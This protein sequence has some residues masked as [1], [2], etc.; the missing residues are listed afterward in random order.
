MSAH[1]ELPPE[2]LVVA[3]GRPEVAS[4]G[5]QPQAHEAA[6][7]L[8][9]QAGAEP[10]VRQAVFGLVGLRVGDLDEVDELG[11]RVRGE[12]LGKVAG[13][14]DREV[15]AADQDEAVEVLRGGQG[16]A[17]QAEGGVEL[18]VI[19]PLDLD[20]V[21]ALAEADTEVGERLEGG[22]VDLGVN[23]EEDDRV[24]VAEGFHETADVVGRGV[25]GDEVGGFHD[26]G[27][28]PE[29]NCSR[30]GERCDSDWRALWVKL[31]NP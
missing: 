8:S 12:E 30:F 6:L 27:Q 14:A 26:G 22:L 21:G 1:Q 16:R 17:H 20:A 18:G 29:K 4:F 13:G 28:W 5:K 2:G 3:E 9:G 7:D 25:G 15:C 31:V 24:R 10:A 23:V 19:A 11:L